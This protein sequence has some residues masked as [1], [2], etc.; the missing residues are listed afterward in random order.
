MKDVIGIAWFKD[1]LTYGKAL[2]MFMDSKDM[3]AS[4]DA[5]RA[6]VGRQCAEIKAAGNIALRVDIEPEAFADW[7]RVQ[8]F[9]P[10][11]VARTSFVN[12][13][14]IEYQKTGKGTIIE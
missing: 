12:H 4:Y 1:E 8:G 9:K 7:C 10:D 6:I 13:V 2:A 14:E 5:W 3:P 11:A